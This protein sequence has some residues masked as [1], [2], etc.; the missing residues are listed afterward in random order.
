MTLATR[1]FWLAL[2]A[3]IAVICV[4]F[5]PA[6]AGAFDGLFRARTD[7]MPSLEGGTGWFNG[8]PVTRESLRGKVVLGRAA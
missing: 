1:I 3:L 7:S 8:P 6:Q 4:R 2:A 5:S